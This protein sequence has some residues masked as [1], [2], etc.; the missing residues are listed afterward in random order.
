MV[1]IVQEIGNFKRNFVKERE[2]F[3]KEKKKKQT[4]RFITLGTLSEK[5][6]EKLR[7]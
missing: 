2:T 5:N 3:V 6:K 7:Q 4:F 1:L